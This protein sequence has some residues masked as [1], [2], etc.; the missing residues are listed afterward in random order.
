MKTTWKNDWGT[1]EKGQAFTYER[2]NS[3]GVVETITDKIDYV[4]GNKWYSVFM[5]ENGDEYVLYS[6]L[7]W[8]RQQQ[9]KEYNQ[10]GQR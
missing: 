8:K 7:W 2:T 5:L 10:Y 6:K 3:E 9:T 1:Y 4:S